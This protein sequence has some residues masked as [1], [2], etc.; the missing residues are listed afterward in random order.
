MIAPFPLDYNRARRLLYGAVEWCDIE[1]LMPLVSRL[2]LG[3]AYRCAELR[4]WLRY[5]IDCDW[6]SSCLGLP[7]VK[8]RTRGVLKEVFGLLDVEAGLRRRFKTQS[9][10]EL[11]GFF[12]KNGRRKWPL[13]H[14]FEP[15]DWFDGLAD[16]RGLVLVTA[17]FDSCWAGMG[18]LAGHGRAVNAVYDK[19][20]YHP[21][22]FGFFQRHF[23]GKYEGI[24]R[25]Y[26]GGTLL[27]RYDLKREGEERLARG[28]II[29]F[30][31]DVPR[32]DRGVPV[33][34]LGNRVLVPFGAFSYAMRSG[35]PIA[36]YVTRCLGPGLYRTFLGRPREIESETG[37][38]RVAQQVY[39]ELE[40]IL[41][42]D[43]GS[44]WAADTFFEYKG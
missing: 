1:L 43:P 4:G 33:T 18:F 39:S 13:E 24:I 29:V 16:S 44:W 27:D 31:S 42:S 15:A 25:L 10:E 19:I 41:R 17:H 40:D 28:E 32:R 38:E 5:H 11:E 2:P 8:A 26:N 3:L 22:V 30:F 21:R 36:V 14:T 12:I 6:R 23:R 7:F 20:V 35:V 9:R 37:L 34:F